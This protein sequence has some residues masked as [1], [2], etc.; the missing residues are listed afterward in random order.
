MD[1]SKWL[2]AGAGEVSH[3]EGL[4]DVL[5]RAVTVAEMSACKQRATAAAS[6]L[7]IDADTASTLEICAAT[8]MDAESHAPLFTAAQLAEM[9]MTRLASLIAVVGEINGFDDDIDELAGKLPR[10]VSA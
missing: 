10:T 9:P 3:V 5:V 1:V 8:V 7:D 2:D 6:K 4:G